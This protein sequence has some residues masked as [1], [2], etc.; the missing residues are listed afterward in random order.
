MMISRTKS[1]FFILLS[2]L[3]CIGLWGWY[4]S[5]LEF[6]YPDA[7]NL[8]KKAQYLERIGSQPLATTEL[9]NLRRENPEWML[10]TLSFSSYAFTNMAFLDSTFRQRAVQHIT[11]AINKAMQDS[12]YAYYCRSHP[13]TS[14][15]SSTSSSTTI[16]TIT[17]TIDSTASVLYLGHLNMML[18]CYRLL[19]PDGKYNALH[20]ALSQS[21]YHRYRAAPYHCLESY[22]QHIWIPDNTVALASLHLYGECTGQPQ[23]DSLCKDWVNYAK[24]NFSDDATQTLCSTINPQDGSTMEEARGSMLGWA[25]LFIYR[26]DKDYA[27]QLYTNYKEHFSNNLLYF[28]LFKERAGNYTI[29]E[30]D[31]DSGPL[32]LGY[33]IPATAWALG[34]AVVLH[35]LPTAR[36]IERLILCGSS[37]QEDKGEIC[38]ETRVVNLNFSPLSEALLLFLETMTEWKSKSISSP[39]A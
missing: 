32:L 34:N 37:Q 5:G 27:Q 33:S 23:F 26:F 18:G 39:N 36:S 16:S 15:V 4:L 2:L 10:F 22:P 12:I 6:H 3:L 14:T 28:R 11:H 9:F 29:G 38:Y 1:V 21:L 25:I 31:I 20:D 17:L 7:E 24:R 35:D 19:S 8:S 30:G 13:F